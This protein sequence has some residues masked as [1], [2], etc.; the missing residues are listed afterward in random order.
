MTAEGLITPSTGLE[1]VDNITEEGKVTVPTV[2][3]A[4]IK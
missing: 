4:N 3:M 1:Y 2:N